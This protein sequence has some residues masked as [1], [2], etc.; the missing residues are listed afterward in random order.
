MR[1]YGQYCPVAKAAEVFADHWTPLIVR[2]LLAGSCQFNELMR[3]LPG[4]PR[5]LLVQRLRRLERDGIIQRRV[6][7]PG[8]A[9]PYQMTPAGEELQRV[10]TVLGEWGARWAL[11]EPDPEDLD[12][13]L[14]LWRM[15]RRV[16][17]DHLPPR[18]V[19]VQF[20]FRG[21]CRGSYWL[22]IEPADASVCL[23][24]PGFDLDVLVT[25]DIA[26]FYRVWL[27]RMTLAEAMRHDTVRLDGTP[28]LVRAF[29][30]WFAWSPF[31]EAVRAAATSPEGR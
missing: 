5:A 3:G 23:Q 29:P 12:P 20:D 1:T 21:G 2:E 14:L 8:R 28:A 26:A 16:N 18:R 27:G 6:G 25:A 22:V 10:I 31:V 15:R 24:D 9:A 17:H 19:V 7:V 13:G 30:R 11:G 4:I